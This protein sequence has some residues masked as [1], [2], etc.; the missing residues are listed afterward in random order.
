MKISILIPCHNEE[1]SIRTCINSCLD[2]TRKPDEIVV[3]NDGSNDRSS[4]ILKTFGKKIRVYDIYPATGN[5]SHAQEYG[6]KF[7]TG[8]VFISTDGDTKLDGH[9]VERVENVFKD[10]SVSAMGGYVRSLKLNWITTCR[11]FDYT[12]GQKIHKQAQN[13]MN[14]LMVIPGAAGAFRTDIFKRN[15]K[16]DHDTITE[17]LDFTYKIHKLN[18]KIVYDQ[19]AIVCTQDPNTISSYINQMRRWFGGGWQNLAKHIGKD[20][21]REPRI[22]L[23]LSL[24]Y[25]EGLVYSALLFIVP[26][27]NIILFVKLLGL[28]S[29]VIFLQSVYA[30]IIE[31]RRDVLKVVFLYPI[32]MYINAYVFIEQFIKEIIFK[33]K[34][35]VWFQPERVNI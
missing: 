29:I 27:I 9:F 6:L 15:I 11:A 34:S 7:I 3:V 5:K 35:M 10:K 14:F 12:I 31:K 13:Y 18:L 30:A 19:K 33:N 21:Y 1:K 2:Q 28:L 26:L 20:L 23:E 22:V 4:E 25:I 16:F 8:E 32:F 17:D 24:I